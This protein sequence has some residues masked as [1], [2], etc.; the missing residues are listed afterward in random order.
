MRTQLV[1]ILKMMKTK[2]IG[3]TMLRELLK[4]NL[5]NKG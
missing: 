5:L 1:A 4:P 2:K 3:Q